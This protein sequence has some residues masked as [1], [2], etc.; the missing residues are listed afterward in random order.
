[1]PLPAGEAGSPRRLA[2]HRVVGVEEAGQVIGAGVGGA[3][4]GDE[5]GSDLPLVADRGGE[6]A[7]VLEVLVEHEDAGLERRHRRG[8]GSSSP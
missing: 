3:D 1:M 8:V 7:R 6:G 2:E 4:A 5:A